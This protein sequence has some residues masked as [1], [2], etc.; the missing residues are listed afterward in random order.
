LATV[1]VVPHVVAVLALDKPSCVRAD[2]ADG[3]ED[4]ESK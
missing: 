4:E 2:G 1:W 3:A